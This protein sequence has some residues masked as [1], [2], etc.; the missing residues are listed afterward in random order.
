MPPD[1]H[2]NLPQL[3]QTETFLKALSDILA[4]H[5]LKQSSKVALPEAMVKGYITRPRT[6]LCRVKYR[7][8]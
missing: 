1:D 7:L 2:D 4:R 8:R 3:Y 6:S 5:E